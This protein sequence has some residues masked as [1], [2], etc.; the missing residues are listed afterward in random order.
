M[1]HAASLCDAR[2]STGRIARVNLADG[3]FTF[4]EVLALAAQ[5]LTARGEA[6]AV[7]ARLTGGVTVRAFLRERYGAVTGPREYYTPPHRTPDA[8]DLRALRCAL[9]RA[10]AWRRAQPDRAPRRPAR[11]AA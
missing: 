9:R 10:G 2:I 4:C 1:Q 11:R 8:A 6:A 3:C 5:D 7:L